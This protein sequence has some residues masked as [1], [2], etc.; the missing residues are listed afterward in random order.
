LIPVRQQEYAAK[1]RARVQEL[2]GDAALSQDRL[3]TEI[4]L[5]AERLD[6]T[7]EIVRLESPSPSFPGY[8][9]FA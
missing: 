8:L 1:M 9:G 4:G 2:I 3:L 7:E 6:V 5:M